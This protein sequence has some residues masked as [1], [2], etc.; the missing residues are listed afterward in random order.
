[1][2][3]I[4]AARGGCK[5]VFRAFLVSNA[6]YAGDF[7]FPCILPETTIPTRLI[8][9]SKAIKSND[10]D[11]WVHF[12]E[13]DVAFERIWNNPQRYLSILK[14]FAG[15][16]TP[17]FSLYRDMPLI[18][19]LWNIYRSHAIGCW[20][21]E[22]GVHVITNV[23]FADERTY[24]PCCAGVPKHSAIAVG[25]HGCIRSWDD[26]A[27]FEQGLAYVIS[28]LLPPVI[29]VYG[30]APDTIFEKYKKSGITILHFDSECT[31]A[32]RKKVGN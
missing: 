17:D 22:N 7:E 8:S 10:Y 25:S 12:Y 26:R 14:R 21:Q 13:D 3:K 15:V 24:A 9:F 29:I 23:R 11:A 2:S 28:E 5:D 4:N 18:M 1:M 6:T 19:Q 30:S 32:H 16:I 31:I 27:F 20:L